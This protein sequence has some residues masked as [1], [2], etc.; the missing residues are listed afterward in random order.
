MQILI[1]EDDPNKCRNI[2]EF[3]HESRFSTQMEILEAHS[4]QSGLALAKARRPEL[5][6]LD[7]SLPT[8]DISST[9]TGGSLRTYGGKDILNE[10][11]RKGIPSRVIIV[12]QFDTFGEGVRRMTLKQLALGLA[13]DFPINYA[14]V[15][16]YDAARSDW[17]SSLDALIRAQV[18][19]NSED[20]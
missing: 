18:V 1:V 9:E 12:T 6:L 14:G 10:L 17:K 13:R 20:N 19:R 11:Q 2:L 5:V 7:M 3:L 16:Y 4:Y 15:V 8:F